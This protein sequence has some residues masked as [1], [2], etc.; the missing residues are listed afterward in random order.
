M[1]L[2]FRA[3][4]SML[5]AFAMFILIRNID[6]VYVVLKGLQFRLCFRLESTFYCRLF[7]KKLLASSSSFLDRNLSFACLKKCSFDIATVFEESYS[8]WKLYLLFDS[9]KYICRTL[10]T[11]QSS[12]SRK[13]KTAGEKKISWAVCLFPARQN[14]ET[15][16]SASFLLPHLAYHLG[17]IHL[18]CAVHFSSFTLITI[19][20][21]ILVE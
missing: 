15:L 9:E 17:E 19:K 21:R 6:F 13:W 8:R 18:F 1:L 11:W 10:L 3:L 14:I 7:P 4:S 20:R 16:K 12:S 5:T 2:Y